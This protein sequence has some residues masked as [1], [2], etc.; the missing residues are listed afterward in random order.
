MGSEN[1]P[2]LTA[3]QLA[4]VLQV[5][6]RTVYSLARQGRIPHLRVG[7]SLRFR[8]EQVEEALAAG[9]STS[10]AERCAAETI[11]RIRRGRGEAQEAPAPL[12]P[13]DWSRRTGG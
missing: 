4:E 5:T 11:A 6:P 3:R 2:A 13:H 7:R 8:L 12:P 9:P 1:S 10:Q